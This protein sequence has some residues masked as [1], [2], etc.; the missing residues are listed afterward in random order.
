MVDPHNETPLYSMVKNREFEIALKLIKR[1]ANVNFVNSRHQTPL[2]QCIETMNIDG[3]SFL[4]ANDAN[5][6]IE[7][8]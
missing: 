4:L 7:D 6:H 1:G 8:V 2:L 5:P 3:I